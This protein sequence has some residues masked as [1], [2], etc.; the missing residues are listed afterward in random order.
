[1]GKIK[2]D[3]GWYESDPGHSYYD[4][5]GRWVPSLTQCLKLAGL[6]DYSGVDPDVLENAARR[7]TEVHEL[8]A[9]YNRFGELDPAW[10]TDETTPYFNGYLQFLDDTG[11]KP[12]PQWTEVPM[13]A[14]IHGMKVGVTPDCHGQ[15]KRDNWVLELK[16]TAARQASWSVQTALQECA[17]YKTTRCGR[18]R[19][20]ALMLM[21]DGKYRLGEEHTNHDED[22]DAGIAAL[23][24]VWWRLSHGQDLKK[25]L[26]I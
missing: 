23:K 14:T 11:F 6:S 8:A 1:M 3:G 12:D 2:I 16:A 13:I 17:I 22:M 9:T 20:F 18:A 26:A 24:T 25:R 7:G 21:K 15:H 10:L 4:D 19:R 5:L